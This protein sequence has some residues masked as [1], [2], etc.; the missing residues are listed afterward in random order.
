MGAI[1]EQCDMMLIQE[2]NNFIRPARNICI[3]WSCSL[4]Y[5]HKKIFET[6]SMELIAAVSIKS[7][8]FDFGE[9]AYVKTFKVESIFDDVYPDS[10]WIK[11]R[12]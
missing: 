8:K 5:V 10:M 2:G 12:M 7:Y 6:T 4:F 9:K 1:I 11:V 3:I